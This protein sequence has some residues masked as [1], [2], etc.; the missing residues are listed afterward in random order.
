[1]SLE[2]SESGDTLES[3]LYVEERLDVF[4]HFERGVKNAHKPID[5]LETAVDIG[6]RMNF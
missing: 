6:R 1:M 3:M 2:V 4:L 5:C